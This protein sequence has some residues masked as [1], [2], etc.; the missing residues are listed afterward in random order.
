MEAKGYQLT[1][2]TDIFA[3]DIQISHDPNVDKD[4]VLMELSELLQPLGLELAL[5]KCSSTRMV[6]K[7]PFCDSA[8]SFMQQLQCI[9]F[10]QLFYFI[11]WDIQFALR[12]MKTNA[13]IDYQLQ[14]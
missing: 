9:Q 6:V 5:E 12:Q 8:S 7:S 4:M 3:D 11:L 2:F 10:K 14:Y 13:I 1:I